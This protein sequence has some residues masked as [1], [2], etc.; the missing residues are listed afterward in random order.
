MM[1]KNSQQAVKSRRV[2]GTATFNDETGDMTFRA[3]QPGE[4]VQ[5]N[6]R[7]SGS[8]SFYETEGQGRSSYVCHL[9]VDRDSADPAAEMEEQLQRLTSPI[10][11][12]P[13]VRL[14]GRHLLD[15]DGVKVYHDRRCN[16]VSVLMSIDLDAEGEIS[17][18][19]FNLT[20]EVN[21]CFAINRT[22][23][24]PQKK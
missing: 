11:K 23:L 1:T 5:K 12:K 15:K 24:T 13:V 2:R 10:R 8:S 22:S 7:R 6:V 14:R 20:A 9:K 19:L 4:P 16:Q 17:A 21:K 3:V 18:K